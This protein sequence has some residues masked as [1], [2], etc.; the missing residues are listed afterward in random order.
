MTESSGEDL[1]Q[2]PELL[3]QVLTLLPVGIRIADGAGRIVYGNPAAHAVWAGK[4]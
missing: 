1:L 2:R 4:R 3:Q